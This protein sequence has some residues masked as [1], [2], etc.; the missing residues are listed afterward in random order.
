MKN[1]IM[2]KLVLGLFCIALP[3]LI[4][5]CAIFDRLP[6]VEVTNLPDS[7]DVQIKKWR[8][9]GPLW[10]NNQN[11]RL[12]HSVL[13][14]DNLE[15]FNLTEGMI[16]E[17]IFAKIKRR[18]AVKKQILPDNFRNKV[19]ATELDHINLRMI[20]SDDKPANA[21]L[22]CMLHSN[23]PKEVVFLLG[24]D[25]GLK[26]WLN[27]NLLLRLNVNRKIH[28]YQN[29]IRVKLE[30]G[31]NFLLV[32]A[33]HL[34]DDWRLLFNVCSTTQGRREY[35]ECS[36][37]DFLQSSII[38]KDD[39][40]KI[41]LGLFKDY[42]PAE[43]KIV[44]INNETMLQESVPFNGTWQHDISN[45]AE[46]LYI[47]KVE[48]P[49]DTFQQDFYYGDVFESL[50]KYEERASR[51]IGSRYNTH[52]SPSSRG[53]IEPICIS[54][55]KEKMDLKL[56]LEALFIRYKHLLE[57]ESIALANYED[58]R[59]WKKKVVFVIGELE[60]MLIQL[61]TGQESIKHRT[62]THLRGYFSEIDSSVQ[63]YMLYVPEEYIPQ[64]KIPLIIMMPYGVIDNLPFLKN[65]FVA[66][67]LSIDHNIQFA[68]EVG[69]AILWP[70][71][72]GNTYGAP[73]EYQDLFEALAA[74][75]KDYTIDENRIYLNGV[76][77]GGSRAL[78]LACR[79]PHLFAAVGLFSPYTYDSQGFLAMEAN[80]IL[81]FVPNLR[82]I[83]IHI[84]HG[85][86]DEYVPLDH[87]IKL[88][89]AA[90]K[91]NVAVTLNRLSGIS[92]FCYPN[93]I[94]KE[95]YQ[96]F[97]DKFT[98]KTPHNIH[99]KTTELKYGT[100][101]WLNIK[102][103]SGEGMA[104][105]SA[106]IK[107]KNEITVTTSNIAQYKLLLDKLP[108]DPKDDLVLRTNG[109]IIYQ[110]K[111]RQSVI[112]INLIAENHCQK[113]LKKHHKLRDH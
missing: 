28:R 83:T 113:D 112:T 70:H 79:Y 33:N 64:L 81:D 47:C 94:Q 87:S 75:K 40:L 36:T 2:K 9:A 29:F 21:Y 31:D 109:K 92:H 63:H 105:I 106:Q 89:Q 23:T 44:N 35:K 111:P 61:E 46:G 55:S 15:N 54:D 108:M 25:N 68:R 12:F 24:S 59:L 84:V 78:L 90:E 100:S 27:G 67:I 85:D 34:K 96:F 52:L 8:V 101:Y 6:S 66:D 56:N 65:I 103:K 80:R 17:E 71:L 57:P 88:I 102:E 97:Q 53:Q 4:N 49:A 39:S 38:P 18:N 7:G 98:K 14:E 77:I 43:I 74:V 22:A 1:I 37:F 11:S 58:L 72:R 51:F 42:D 30:Q 76:C 104:E 41:D 95:I 62:G 73:I 86:Q 26:V 110:D 107:G 99:F 50:P 48:F 13:D 60:D 5:T 32:K 45:L 16:N 3:V 82:Y 19:I 69:C 93:R 20:L 10:V 91:E